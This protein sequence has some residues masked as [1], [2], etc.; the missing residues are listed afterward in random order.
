MYIDGEWLKNKAE[1]PVINPATGE[2]IDYVPD[3]DA[4]HASAAIEGAYRAL[5]GWM[6]LTAYQRSALL[7]RANR[8][9]LEQQ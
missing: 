9:M 1:F 3:G 2:V 8:L 7:Y 5:P 4:G 6:A